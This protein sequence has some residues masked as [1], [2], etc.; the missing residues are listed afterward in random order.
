MPATKNDDGHAQSA[1]PATKT[2][3]HLLKTS[4]KYCPCHAKRF[5]TRCK[6]RPN[7]TKCHAC[8]AKRSNDTSE[9]SKHDHLCKI[10]HGYGHMDLVRTVANSCERLRTVANSCERLR[11]VADGCGRLRTAADADAT[12]SEHTL[13]PQTPRV[14][15]EPLLR[16]REKVPTTT[17]YYKACTDYF[18]V[19]LCTTKLA[20]TT[21]HY[22]FVLQSLQ[23][24]S[25]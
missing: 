16:I 18:P 3:I 17:L 5:S 6:T 23:N 13:N 11:T 25:M 22:Y 1:A 9:T 10:S 19:L 21:S 7:V 8:H 14:K 2:A 24:T 4:Q 15:R 20:Q 12:S